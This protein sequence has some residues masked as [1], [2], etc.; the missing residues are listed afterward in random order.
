MDASKN[1]ESTEN[2]PPQKEARTEG[3]RTEGAPN[4]DA[5]STELLLG[6]AELKRHRRR[7]GFAVLAGVL[8]AAIAVPVGVHLTGERGH[9]PSP[10]AGRDAARQQPVEA[11]EAVRE[12][13]RTGKDVEVTARHTPDSTTWARPDGLLRTRTYSDTIRARVGGEWKP[14]DT[15]LQHVDGGYTPRAVNDPLLF[16]AGSADHPGSRG[17]AGEEDGGGR[18]SRAT[19][20]TPLPGAGAVSPSSSDG[21]WTDLVRM[22]TGGHDLVVRWPGPL[23][24]PLVNGPRALYQNV[25][26]GIDLLLTAR[27]GGYSH[28]LVVHTRQAA[29]DPLLDRLDYRLSSPSLSF[30]LDDATDVVSARD[31]T[32][33]EFAS[34]PTP[35]V[36]DSA[37]AVR[38]TIGEPVPAPDPAVG[39][40]ALALPGLA[41]PQPGSHDAV[42]DASLDD[43][44]VLGLDVD[45]ELLAD[46][47]TVYPV[48][49]DPSFKGRKKNWT[50]LYAKYP[51]SS[52]YN[53]Q[54]FNDGTNDARVGYE[55]T[56]GGLSRSVFTFEYGS[57]LHGTK[58]QSAT[59]R[60]LQTYSWGCSSRQYNLYLTGAISSSSTWNKQ[61][62]WTRVLSSQTNGHGYKSGSCPDKWVAMDIKSAAQ[63]ASDKKWTALTLG[64]RAANESDTN[65]WKKFQANGESSPY[66]EVVYN[67]A[68]NE[69]TGSLM[70]TSPGGTCDTASPYLSIGK[71]DITFSS[72]ASDADGNLKYL[73]L[74]VWRT[75]FASSPL[76]DA[77]HATNSTGAMT[78]Y[79]IP[80]SSF[81]HGATY[82][83]SVYSK[84][85]EGA[86][87]AWGPPHTTALCQFTVDHSA[88]NSPGVSSAAF[89]PPGDDGSTWSTSAFGTA[90]QFVFTPNGPAAGVKEYQYS[91]N[92]AFDKKALP[93]SAN[94]GRAVVTLQPPHAGPSVL[95]VRSADSVGNI[96]GVTKYLFN[97]RPSPQLD[98]AGDVTG[99]QVPDVYTIDPS[100]NLLLYAKTQGTDRLHFSMAAAYSAAGDG[101]ALLDDGYWTDALI[102]HNGDWLPGDGI[103]DLVARMPDG[104]LYVYPGDGYG[105][106]DVG[107]RREMLLPGGAPATG[108]LT[109]IL[110]VGDATG[111]GRPDLLATAGSG[112]WAFTGYTGAS[113]SGVTQL[114]GDDWS[115]RDLVQ[116]D[117]V[118]GGAGLDLVYRTDTTGRIYLRQGKLAGAGT[119]LSSFAVQ[120]AAEGG[121]DF[122]YGSAGWHSDDV[123]FVLGTPDVTGDGV[124]DV[125]AVRSDGNASVYLGSGAVRL[126]STAM[127]NV[128]NTS[129]GTSWSGHTAIG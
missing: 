57:T 70:K 8:A 91:F 32:G 81:T 100:G 25:R 128:V 1:V 28:V 77:D 108:A 58:V 93:D 45:E 76:H 30:T 19:V 120:T 37:G 29:Q 96:S 6:C 112:L 90:G 125:W 59:F 13:R 15:T 95:Y 9:E 75:G 10:R 78:P 87:S 31:S 86:T 94:G 105:G 92:T 17:G 69:P 63:E 44:G 71:Q 50:L 2:S 82:T 126:G 46:P 5:C 14:V 111:D 124:P 7:R 53:G 88:P 107:Q 102:S 80:W 127:F 99:D 101:A 118:R 104:K 39:S 79:T 34:S 89:P 47:E 20:R 35:Y 38:A 123:P 129:V 42:L 61:P 85:A 11:A 23:P 65:A 12:A 33:E 122:L 74:K 60:A 62:S 72:S 51:G 48:F 18:A 114:S 106:F 3:A 22:T 64:L 56:T 109:Q 21:T 49:I 68:P 40:T 52:F 84:D 73:H 41:G 97:V 54:N 115:Q 119:D 83:W 26:P 4:D 55:S 24:E 66:V 103:Q 43:D 110:S 116:V 67:R 36:W 117:D 27:D 16:S 98:A 113:F 121:V